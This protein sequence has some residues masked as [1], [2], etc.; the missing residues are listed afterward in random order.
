MERSLWRWTKAIDHSLSSFCQ[1]TITC[2]ACA[3]AMLESGPLTP[4]QASCCFMGRGWVITTEIHLTCIFT[5][6]KHDIFVQND[7]SS[8]WILL[9]HR[10]DEE[11]FSNS[12]CFRT[13][14]D[15][16]LD[17]Y[18][19]LSFQDIG[20]KYLLNDQKNG[21]L[22]FAVL[23]VVM[24]KK[25]KENLG[26]TFPGIW[27]QTFAP[28][29]YFQSIKRRNPQVPRVEREHVQ[30]VC[31]LPQGCMTLHFCSFQVSFIAS[32][33]SLLKVSRERKH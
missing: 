27:F 9:T 17:P 25:G 24:K 13:W 16:S 6:M 8:E 5:G 10:I 11:G 12:E 3:W 26:F 14:T 18:T 22:D 15:F 30:S 20:Q 29:L 28:T 33:T 23:R 21:H 7:Y 31:H 19:S 4:T 32:L 1:Q 2:Q